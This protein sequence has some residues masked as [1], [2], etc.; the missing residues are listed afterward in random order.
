MSP[1]SAEQGRY[2]PYQLRS[3]NNS[4][5]LRKRVNRAC[6]KCSASRTRCD[7]Q[8]P[9][10]RCKEYDYACLYTRQVKKRGRPPA[11]SSPGKSPMTSTRYE[12]QIYHDLPHHFI[13]NNEAPRS[14]AQDLSENENY[15][16][17]AL[18]VG[19]VDDPTPVPPS[20]SIRYGVS[21]SA[22]ANQSPLFDPSFLSVPRGFH[23]YDPVETDGVDGGSPAG[24]DSRPPATSIASTDSPMSF[25]NISVGRGSF[26]NDAN[27]TIISRPSQRRETGQECRYPFLHPAIPYIR[28]IISVSTAC[29]LFDIFLT[30]PGSSLF[31]C[32]SPFILTKIFR[33]KSM[34]HPTKPRCTTP[35]LIAT[36]LW[37]VA[38]TADIMI[39]QVPGSRPRIV[40]Q[41]YDVITSLISRRDPDRWRHV[42]GSLRADK[43]ATGLGLDG[44]LVSPP[45]TTANEVVGEI[46][47]VLTFLLLTIAVSGLDC[48]PDCQKWWSKATRLVISLRLN[49]EDERCLEAEQP[50][51]NPLCVCQRTQLEPTLANMEQREERRRVFWLCFSLDRHLALSFNSTVLIPDSCCEVYAPLPETVWE[52]LDS[53]PHGD[54]PSRTLA[55]PV[56]ATGTSFFEY[57]LP[58]M[59]I[60]GD[61]IE[62]HHRRQH[63][64]LGGGDNDHFVLSIRK[65]LEQYEGSLVT[66]DDNLL[67][68]NSTTFPHEVTLTT[69]SHTRHEATTS[70]GSSDQAQLQIVRAYG[71]HIMHVLYV[72]LYGKW[73]AICM[74]DDD[75]GWITSGGFAECASHAISA[76]Q[77]IA[78]ILEIDPELTF[79]SYLFGIYLLHG[80]F[81]FLLFADRMPQLG[82]NQSVE[83]ACENIIRAHEVSIVT[84]N[85]E[86]Q[87][88]FRKVL[89]STL[90]SVR[91]L[92]GANM[93]AHRARRRVLSLYRW[94]KGVR[95]LS[96]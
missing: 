58:L 62:I 77:T 55:P 50:C 8:S 27:T 6:D 73:D 93:E 39:L 40:N 38:Q 96:I 43:D 20:N 15:D 86:F 87:R 56:T 45:A 3:H 13:S 72:L 18:P 88:T 44:S 11:A 47:D 84:L 67:G 49:R 7:G 95:G 63:P 2:N 31:H 75:D 57:F 16:E 24:H 60:L 34:L 1:S 35:A 68:A 4:E 12:D 79:M 54:L 9:C 83:L 36:I 42:D 48:K 65:L 53:I 17:A 74:M 46:D 10:R 32:A 76:S 28:D 90:Y 30:D 26:G 21:Q 94:T 19:D 37:C 59:V 51:P 61:I 78:T 69:N 29:E 81:I 70:R 14:S 82:P 89:R 22:L 41:L 23:G 85:T 25:R 52:N 91:G 71:R 5:P 66:L 92:N 80:S 64:R 33:K